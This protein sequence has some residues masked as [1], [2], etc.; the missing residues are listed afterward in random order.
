VSD[1]VRTLSFAIADG[2][3][4]SNEGRGYVLRRILR[5][6]VRYGVQNLGAQPGFLHRLVPKFCLDYGAAYPELT[7]NCAEIVSVIK[8]E[9]DAF[10]LQLAK[11]IDE[12]SRLIKQKQVNK[13]C[14]VSGAEAFFFHDT[15]GFPI[16]LLEIMA[17]ENLL[18]VN[19]EEYR[20]YL[21]KQKLQSRTAMES[22][23]GMCSARLE[24]NGEQ[25]SEL[26]KRG[27]KP[28]NDHGKYDASTNSMENA[29]VLAIVNNGKSL[30]ML[31]FEVT[32]VD[33]PIGLIFNKTNFYS[34]SGGQ[35]G[36]S[37]KIYV[38]N[39]ADG[40]DIELDVAD[41]QVRILIILLSCDC[42]Q[43]LDVWWIRGT[44]M[45]SI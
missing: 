11:A 19:I 42:E 43:F 8:K 14:I 24:L 45:C 3:R 4:P 17:T 6:A 30:E 31:N 37:G 26:R 34:E 44:F 15:L 23:R 33:G 1:H 2:A 18:N 13:D 38:R 22:K 16:D 7:A 39:E 40:K 27:I 12:F 21:S 9:E 41:V 5:R 20:E 32:S 10:N 35:L 28:T 25:I 36:D 29:S